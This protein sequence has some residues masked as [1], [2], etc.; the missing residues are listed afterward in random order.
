MRS[1]SKMHWLAAA[2]AVGLAGCAPASDPED[3]NFDL[4][5]AGGALT[6]SGNLSVKQ[7]DNVTINW[8][9]DEPVSVHLHGYDIEIEVSPDEPEEM[10]LE[11]DATG[12]F[13]IS[14][15]ALGKDYEDAHSHDDTET[16]VRCDEDGP[17]GTAPQLNVVTVR[18]DDP[19]EFEVHVDVEAVS[20]RDL[21]W[22]LYENGVLLSMAAGPMAKV[23]LETPGEHTLMAKLAAESHCEYEIS[24]MTTVTVEEG[25]EGVNDEED[26]ADEGEIE[27][28]LTRLVVN[29]R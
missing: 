15:H 9:T 19:T 2:V 18:L 10:A 27:V 1:F 12:G 3:R 29:P 4:E 28:V 20:P 6:E 26:R 25:A 22:H 14:L 13:D 5:I 16:G 11:A 23:I 21:H 7:G 17:S 8:T 24:A